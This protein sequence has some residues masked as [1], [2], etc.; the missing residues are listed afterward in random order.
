MTDQKTRIEAFK[1]LAP[2]EPRELVG[3]WAGRG[4]PSGHPFDGVLEN[5]GWFGKRFRQDMKADALLFHA[6]DRRLVAVDPNGINKARV[7]F[8]MRDAVQRQAGQW[9]QHRLEQALALLVETDMTLRSS[10]KAPTM[11]LMERALIRL[12]MMKR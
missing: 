3:L 1:R 9:G 6:G 2:I 12:A 7:I 11:A 8:K 5:L 4:I 10:T